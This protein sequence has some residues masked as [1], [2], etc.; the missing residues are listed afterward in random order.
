MRGFFGIGVERI[1]KAM[2]LGNLMRSANAFGASF[3]F[4]V[5]ADISERSLRH[6]DTSDA[7]DQ[8]PVYRFDSV[9]ELLLPRG[10]Q[11]VGVEL[12]DEAEALP[13]FYHPAAAAY[14]LGPERGSLSPEMLARC[15]RVVK[16]PMKFCV[17]VGTAGAIVMYDRLLARGRF[18]HRATSSLGRPEPRPAHVHG[19]VRIRSTKKV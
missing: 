2:N 15:D 18:E 5:A 14:V 7:P 13:S 8:L 10:C 1:S 4:T 12:T 3:F 17:N 6:A 9:G 16:I 19:P 11:L